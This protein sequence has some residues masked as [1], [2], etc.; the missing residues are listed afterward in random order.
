MKYYV[1]F[2]LCMRLNVQSNINI[3]FT[4]QSNVKV[5]VFPLKTRTVTCSR[6]SASPRTSEINYSCSSDGYD[7]N[8][9]VVRPMYQ[10]CSMEVKNN[11]K[12]TGF[13]IDISIRIIQHTHTHT[14]DPLG[15]SKTKD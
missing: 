4:A 3:I 9:N 7:Q 2:I 14:E 11:N 1:Y 6:H 8:N 10:M 13:I 15:S 5:T 12:N